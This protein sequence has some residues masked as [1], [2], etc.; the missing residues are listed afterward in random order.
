M[1]REELEN[2]IA[3]MINDFEDRS[4]KASQQIESI[5]D[6]YEKIISRLNERVRYLET[7]L[8]LHYE[9]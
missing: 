6:E 7:Q 9:E 2:K 1:T 4:W 5:H 8:R 3:E